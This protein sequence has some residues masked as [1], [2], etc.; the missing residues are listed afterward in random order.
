MQNKA[1]TDAPVQP[2]IIEW[3]DQFLVGVQEID[4]Q[5]RALLWIASKVMEK[6]SNREDATFAIRA[7]A[8]S[9]VQHFQQEETWMSVNDY[10]GMEA[11]QLEHRRFLVKLKSIH[12]QAIHGPMSLE[13]ITFVTSWL[14]G[15]ILSFDKPT[16]SYLLDKGIS[17]GARQNLGGK[18][19]R[20]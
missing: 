8:R 14:Y 18:A 12:E 3:N 13:M 1:G 20:N 10:V 5:H 17:L 9:F 11:H 7:L 15:H 4:A 16:F 19:D 6:A 2:P